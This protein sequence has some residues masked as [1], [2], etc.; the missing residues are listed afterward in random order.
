MR[1]AARWWL[2]GVTASAMCLAACKDD[3]PPPPQPAAP[4]A[5]TSSPTS[6]AVPA[7]TSSAS[8]ALSPDAFCAKVFGTV[9]ADSTKTCTDA[10]KKTD[11]YKIIADFADDP[12]QECQST[13]VAA[14]A[15]GR[16]SFNEPAAAACVTAAAKAK[17]VA[18]REVLA[19]ADLD[20]I[21]T[22]KAIVSGNQGDGA[23][24]HSSLECAPSLTCLGVTGKADGA[25][26]PLPMKAGD[27]CDT[28][29][30]KLHDLGHRA[31]C[32]SGLL[33]DPLDSV[34]RPAVE[35]GGACKDSVQCEA[36]L[37]CHAGKCDKNPPAKVGG[38]CD[39]DTDDCATGLFCKK[40][41][42]TTLGKC[43]EKKDAGAKC[44]T[45]LEC[46]GECHMTDG[47]KDGTCASFCGSG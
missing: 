9:L 4:S 11:L 23:A 6:S 42:G 36:P 1:R 39:D 35:S 40:E 45:L 26:K 47:T 2:G 24:C 12:L 5:T 20:E 41:K 34:C 29:Y 25:C 13:I 16:L 10:D 31:R 43:A 15:S 37:A 32:A 33:C 30:L 22:C 44:A 7:A 27:A 3:S 38:A 17:T 21:D 18:I 19:I 28:V 14:V 46:K 8:P